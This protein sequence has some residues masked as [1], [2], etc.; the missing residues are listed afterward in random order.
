MRWY[1]KHSSLCPEEKHNERQKGSHIMSNPGDYII[2]GNLS[3]G[4]RTLK[5]ATILTS[6]GMV[7]RSGNVKAASTE[8]LLDC[9]GFANRKIMTLFCT[10]CKAVLAGVATIDYWLL[11]QVVPKT[12]SRKCDS[13]C[14]CFPPN[15]ILSS[16]MCLLLYLSGKKP[17][18]QEWNSLF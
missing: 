17:H 7:G 3:G 8:I 4:D 18:G 10:I 11:L 14:C 13:T 1:H 12:I 2:F 15:Q 9:E 5:L 6:K 16:K